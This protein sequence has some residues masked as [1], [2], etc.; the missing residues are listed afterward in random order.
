MVSSSALPKP[1]PNGLGENEPQRSGGFGVRYPGIS[2]ERQTMATIHI[3]REHRLGREAARQRLDNL[4]H[5]LKDKLEA[6]LRWEGDRLVFE[7]SGASGNIV[8]GD[9]FVEVN[10]RLG[11]LLS[12]MRG[13]LEQA[14]QRQLDEELA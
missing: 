14:I 12:P 4:I 5:Y 8:I 9:D 11:L 3:R 13:M 10:A 7:R 1:F 6:E 2:G